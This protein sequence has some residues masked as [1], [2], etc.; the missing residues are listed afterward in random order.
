MDEADL[1]CSYDIVLEER[2][3]IGGVEQ[4]IVEER[5]RCIALGVCETTGEATPTL[6]GVVD[7]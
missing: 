1:V 7:L 3:G 6:N 4:R 5:Y 2:D